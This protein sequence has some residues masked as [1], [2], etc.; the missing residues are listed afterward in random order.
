[1]SSFYRGCDTVVLCND[2]VMGFVCFLTRFVKVAHSVVV[3]YLE[4]G[5]L[6][7]RFF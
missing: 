4:F 2:G 7:L 3:S 1:M 5:T 6:S